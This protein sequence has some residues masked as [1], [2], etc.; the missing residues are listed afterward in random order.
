MIDQHYRN[1]CLNTEHHMSNK[2]AVRNI[3]T[4][5]MTTIIWI[6]IASCADNPTI[7]K[8]SDTRFYSISERPKVFIV[9]DNDT[10]TYYKIIQ[11]KNSWELSFPGYTE[12]FNVVINSGYH[13][14]DNKGYNGYDF[15]HTYNSL[16]GAINKARNSGDIYTQVLGDEYQF[17]DGN[18][19]SIHPFKKLT[20]N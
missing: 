4:L 13:L 16:T 15:K 1:N 8:D 7:Y 14:Y 3:Y 20:R 10:K 19:Y 12:D 2:T 11:F 6:V 5:L 18:L 17:R 9:Y